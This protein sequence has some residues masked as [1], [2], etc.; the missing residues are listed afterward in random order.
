MVNTYV[1]R[2]KKSSIFIEFFFLL[3]IVSL[4]TGTQFDSNINHI[5]TR[6]MGP[7]FVLYTLYKFNKSREKLPREFYLYGFFVLWSTTGFLFMIDTVSY[8]K[9]LKLIVQIEILLFCVSYAI[10]ASKSIRA[11]FAG[12]LIFAVGMSIYMLLNPQIAYNFAYDPNYQLSSGGFN[13]NALGMMYLLGIIGI[14]YFWNRHRSVILKIIFASIFTMFT[15]G[16]ILAASR[17]T[18]MIF[19]VFILLYMYLNNLGTFRRNVLI[20]VPIIFSLVFLYQFY[21]YVMDETYLGHRLRQYESIDHFRQESDRY[22]MAVEGWR[23]FLKNP[24]TGLGLA[25][26]RAHS[27][28]GQYSHSDYFEVL[29]TTGLVG[30]VLYFS[31]YA[32]LLL[33]LFRIKKFVKDKKIQDEINLFISIIVSILLLGLGA[34]IFLSIFLMPIVM[35]VAAYTSNIEIKYRTNS[36]KMIIKYNSANMNQGRFNPSQ[37]VLRNSN[38]K[39]LNPEGMD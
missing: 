7:L 31:I 22:E 12:Y 32:T 10:L 23:F 35:G 36:N 3:F 21:Q 4:Y 39:Y 5:I 28:T 17:K 1:G 16:V 18:F 30:A 15:Y 29:S 13:S 19:I 20:L 9:Y 38:R 27:K 2:R 6:V 11:L 26:F 33:K 25:Q 37:A 8:F 24:I 14:I 34:P